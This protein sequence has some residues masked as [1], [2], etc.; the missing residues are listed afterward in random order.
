MSSVTIYDDRM[1]SALSTLHPGKDEMNF[2]EFPI[3]MLTDRVPK[4]QRSI[5]FEDQV[6]DERKKK[7]VPR[8]RLIEGSAEYGLPNA[9]DD[10]VILALIQ[11]TKQ[12]ND[13]TR[14]EIEFSRHELIRIL[15]WPNEGKS[16]DRIKNSLMRIK[17]VN[18]FYDNAWWDS[19]LKAWTTRAFSIIDNV[20]INDSRAVDSQGGL[21][22][23]RV[24]WNEIVFDSLKAGFVRDLDFQLC[25]Q[26]EHPTALRMYRFLGKRFYLKP[27]LTFD[28]KE[29]AHI[30]LNLGRNYEGGKQISR[31]LQPAILELEGVGFL[32]PLPDSERFP[33]KGRDWTIRFVKKTP[34]PVLET[35]GP[36]E[37]D[38]PSDALLETITAELISRGVTAKIAAK[39]AAAHPAEA[40]QQKIDQFDWEMLQPKPPS[41]PAGYLVKSIIDDYAVPKGFEPKAVRQKREEAKQA[42]ERQAAETRRSQQAEEAQERQKRQAIDAYWNAL[43]PE[44]QVKLDA[45]AKAEAAPDM[46]K[47]AEPG[48]MQKIGIKLVRDHFIGRLIQAGPS[49][50]EPV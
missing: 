28:L 1:E 10:M 9:T 35:A 19:R 41:K 4:G 40:L 39:L 26:L 18:Y 32:E 3:A 36:G 13:F 31:K 34:A 27:D 15:G 47:L 44:Q 33:K 37:V 49:T 25:M 11:L 6:Y 42:Q 12:K 2:A 7:L 29:F 5:K 21:F 14:C 20:E 45:D 38:D 30:Y 46:L 43:T 16:Y 48:P 22:P 50:V 17:G 24:V 23:S 8:K